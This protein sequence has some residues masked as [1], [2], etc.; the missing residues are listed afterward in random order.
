MTRALEPP[1][2]VPCHEAFRSSPGPQTDLQKQTK[3][4][5]RGKY[6]PQALLFPGMGCPVF[7]TNQPNGLPL[8]VGM[9]KLLSLKVN[10]ILDG[11]KA[12]HFA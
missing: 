8:T 9:E 12:F 7:R 4:L 3:G 11:E 5:L 2:T 1:G 10:E 6:T